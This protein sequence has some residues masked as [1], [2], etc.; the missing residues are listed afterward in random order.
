MSR[1]SDPN[2]TRSFLNVACSQA[3]LSAE[4]AEEVSRAVASQGITVVEAVL[5]QGVMDAV[6]VDMVES[7]LQ[8]ADAFP[9]YEIIDVLG[10]GGMGIVYRARQK[11]LDRQVAIK[12][13][14]VNDAA[15]P[16]IMTRFE[17][18][19]VTVAGLR[20]PNIVMAYDFGRIGNRLYFV[21][22][23]LEGEDLETRIARDKRLDESIAWL[24]ARQAAAGLAHAAERDLVHRDVKPGNLFLVAPPE[25]FVLP[26]GVP[27]VKIT[28]FGLV[29]TGHETES[30]R[31]T[32]AGT[33]LGTPVYMAPEQ[34]S[35][36]A[37]DLRADI[38]ALGATVYHMLAGQPPFSGDTVW[39]IMSAK[40]RGQLPALP[41]IVSARSSQLLRDMLAADPGKRIAT[42][43]ELTGRI[44]DLGL[45]TAPVPSAPILSGALAPK[46]KMSRR[47][48]LFVAVLVL[49]GLLGGALALWQR[50]RS[51]PTPATG[52]VTVS[53][54]PLFDGSLR[55]WRPIEGAWRAVP[56]SEGARILSGRGIIERDF[57]R[58][59][60]YRL[61]VGVDLYR[62]SAVE[63]HFAVTDR[64]PRHVLRYARDSIS[65]GHR[66]DDRTDFIGH[67]SAF[68][69]N[70]ASTTAD[71]APYRELRVERQGDVWLAYLDGRLLETVPAQPEKELPTFRLIAEEGEAH[72][73]QPELARLAPQ[74]P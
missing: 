28:D 68:P 57:P 53:L 45:P 31:L 17:R 54:I 58:W 22:E 46:R 16:M 51:A 18:E 42:Y 36:P 34:F 6:Q 66:G 63:L 47:A 67:V 74:T 43:A 1:S 71:A 62:A 55:D 39:Q 72:F 65:L 9:G 12:T 35:D 13:V 41:P 26:Q 27:M 4:I 14:L 61:T 44:D 20:H 50:S 60:N 7:L 64:G 32:R 15:Q 49:T 52:M 19:A 56:D 25:G 5:R 70:N 21:M 3:L 33:S 23:L 40:M 37:V 59:E 48:Q 29:L 38:Y 2:L 8:P 24:I 73:E 30:M 69:V 10:R 11:N